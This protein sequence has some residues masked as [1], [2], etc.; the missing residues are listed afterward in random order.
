MQTFRIFKRNNSIIFICTARKFGLTETK[1]LSNNRRT[2]IG[3]VHAAAN[4][5][6]GCCREGRSVVWGG[7]MAARETTRGAS[8]GAEAGG[9]PGQRRGG[10]ATSEAAGPVVAGGGVL[11][12]DLSDYDTAIENRKLVN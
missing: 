8:D 9:A 1:K 10:A 6:A 7:G 4:G 12:G 11:R 5:R 3:G 2:L